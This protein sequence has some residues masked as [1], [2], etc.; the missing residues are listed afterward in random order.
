MSNIGQIERETQTR[1]IKLF[2]EQLGYTYYGNWEEREKNS[3]IEVN[4]LAPIERFLRGM[5]R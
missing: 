4:D 5:G 2:K 3:T 1:I